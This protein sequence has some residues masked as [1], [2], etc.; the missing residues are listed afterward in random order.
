[1][2]SVT[3]FDEQRL[4]MATFLRVRLALAYLVPLV[5]LDTLPSYLPVRLTLESFVAHLERN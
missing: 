1:M 5:P 4:N 3:A 2:P